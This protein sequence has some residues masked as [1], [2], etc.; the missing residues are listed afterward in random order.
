MTSPSQSSQRV[1][2]GLA[3]PER[4]FAG[5]KGNGRFGAEPETDCLACLTSPS[6]LGLGP[7]RLTHTAEV[8]HSP[9]LVGRTPGIS[10]EAVRAAAKRRNAQ[11][12]TSARRTGA[13]LSFVSF[14]PLF[15][16]PLRHLDD[17]RA[18]AGSGI[19]EYVDN[20]L[21]VEVVANL[22]L[23]KEHQRASSTNGPSRIL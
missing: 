15:G 14:I 20:R 13:A 6:R 18:L 2:V 22:Q 3:Q 23:A 16:G 7:A 9:P 21:I 19:M 11:G 10:C 8:W 12:G 4:F 17:G 5:R 1:G